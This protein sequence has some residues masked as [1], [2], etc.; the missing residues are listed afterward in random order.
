MRVGVASH[1]PGSAAYTLQ[2]EQGGAPRGRPTSLTLSHG[3]SWEQVL[4]VA[5]GLPV[6][7]FLYMGAQSEPYRSTLLWTR[8]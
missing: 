3:E 8:D 2:L 7:V 1:E 6:V 4:R 5:P